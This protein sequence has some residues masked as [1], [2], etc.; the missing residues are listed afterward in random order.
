MLKSSLKSPS[1]RLSLIPLA[2]PQVPWSH[3]NEKVEESLQGKENGT[4]YNPLKYIPF[5]PCIVSHPGFHTLC[6]EHEAK[7][8]AKDNYVQI[9]LGGNFFDPLGL[10]G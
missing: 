5:I 7:G 4:Q 10:H 3:V 9:G 2:H 8:Q 1:S 6:Q